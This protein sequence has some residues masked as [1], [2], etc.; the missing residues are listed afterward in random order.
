MNFITLI[1]LSAL[2]FDSVGKKL[3]TLVPE[4]NFTKISER[5][6]LSFELDNGQK[7][8]EFFK[9]PF[10]YENTYGFLSRSPAE[11]WTSINLLERTQKK[12][13]QDREVLH[14]LTEYQE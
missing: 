5:N 11:M 13:K 14:K 10:Y 9:E 8:E 2:I 7:M 6:E 4:Q 12:Q 3:S 1:L